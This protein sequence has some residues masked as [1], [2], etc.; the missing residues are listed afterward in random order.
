MSETLPEISV[1]IPTLNEEK[2][3]GDTIG[4]LSDSKVRFE[5]IV[6]DADSRDRTREIAVEQGAR[7]IST[8]IASRAHQMNRGSREAKAP[9]LC[10]LHADTLPPNSFLETISK[11][12]DL[13]GV[14]VGCF[15]YKFNTTRRSLQFN[16]WC[17]R[18]PFMM[19]RGG[20]QSLF[21]SRNLFDKLNG[22]D[23]T[24]AVME[25]YDIIRRA[26]AHADFHILPDYMLVSA[27]KYEHNSYV[28]VNLSNF[29]VF[30]LFYL[31]VDTSKLKRWY[32]RLL[33]HPKE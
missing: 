22:F 2:C 19:F 27:R 12:V 8:S 5:L 32:Y 13:N 7:V 20:D 23:E 30:S 21:I 28:R 4:R 33:R 1:I 6:V 29:L 15:R 11:N 3:I 16:A 26:K 18:L 10:F 14:E 17:T 9:I 24:M 25:D 31:G